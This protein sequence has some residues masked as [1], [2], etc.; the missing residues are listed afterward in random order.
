MPLLAAILGV[1]ILLVG[2]TTWVGVSLAAGAGGTLPAAG[3]STSLTAAT[4]GPG[5]GTFTG[6]VAAR[7]GRGGFG[8]GG[9]GG[10]Y[11]AGRWRLLAAA[12]SVRLWRR[13][14]EAVRTGT[15]PT[16]TAGG[17]GG[18]AT[19]D[20]VSVDSALVKYLEANQGS[21]K[22]LFA[23]VSSQTADAYIIVTGKPIMALGGFSGSDQILTLANSRR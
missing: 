7:G 9:F 10:G 12:A 2:P 22:Y 3:P 5:G 6:G 8:G 14:L 11:G 16:G 23:T 20:G 17:Q 13:R 21:A 15:A 4:G 18:T 19:D 1:G